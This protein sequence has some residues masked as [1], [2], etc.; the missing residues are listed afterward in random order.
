MDFIFKGWWWWTFIAL[1]VAFTFKKA[2]VNFECKEKCLV[3]T[4]TEA[5]LRLMELFCLCDA[6]RWWWCVYSAVNCWRWTLIYHSTTTAVMM[7]I[8][9]Q[10]YYNHAGRWCAKI[11]F[12]V[13]GGS[14]FYRQKG[15]RN[16]RGL[17]L[18]GTTVQTCEK[19]GNFILNLHSHKGLL[20]LTSFCHS[21][22]WKEKTLYTLTSN[23]FFLDLRF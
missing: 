18:P 1:S 10:V 13:Q 8:Y 3:A 15:G 22:K 20:C 19:K 17:P 4:P 16:T 23:W 2:Y 9:F 14:V 11:S 12:F 5:L 6:A 21:W 7:I